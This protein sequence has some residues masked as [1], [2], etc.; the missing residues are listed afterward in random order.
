MLGGGIS[1]SGEK[2]RTQTEKG[3]WNE[4]LAGFSLPVAQSVLNLF[5]TCPVRGTRSSSPPKRGFVAD[6]L[7]SA[8]WII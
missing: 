3:G 8:I 4:Y 6:S 2:G 5:S 1:K 7:S